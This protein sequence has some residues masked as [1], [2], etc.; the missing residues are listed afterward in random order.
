[1]GFIWDYTSL[2]CL[3]S[4]GGTKQAVDLDLGE[5]IIGHI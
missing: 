5:S 3:G 2:S 4:E 1:M